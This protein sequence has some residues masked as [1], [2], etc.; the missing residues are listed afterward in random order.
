M[1]SRLCIIV[2][3]FY[4]Q[5]RN[6]FPHISLYDL[7]SNNSGDLQRDVPIKLIDQRKATPQEGH[8]IERFTPT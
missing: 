8:Y 3:S 5:I 7:V 4:S 6:I 1:M 2:E